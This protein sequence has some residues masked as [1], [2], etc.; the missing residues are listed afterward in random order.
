MKQITE[1]HKRLE[2]IA[3]KTLTEINDHLYLENKTLQEA[4]IYE[5]EKWSKER[6][7]KSTNWDP[8]HVKADTGRKKPNDFAEKLCKPILQYDLNGYFI[9]EWNSQKEIKEQLGINPA[10]I[11]SNLTGLT[12]KAGGF[13]WKLK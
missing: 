3:R 12:K 9:K 13:I 8:N 4:C 1:Q 5:K 6:K 11:W 2:S 10:N 7:G